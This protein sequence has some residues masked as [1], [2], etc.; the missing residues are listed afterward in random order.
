VLLSAS[1]VES[2]GMAIA[3]ARAS[4]CAVIARR[5][6][7]VAE[8]VTPAAGGELVDDDPALVRALLALARDP[9]LRARRVALAEAG[10]LAARSWAAVASEFAALELA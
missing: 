1:R 8:L 3:E 10:R 9:V 7:H 2:F 6:G 5:G 4:G